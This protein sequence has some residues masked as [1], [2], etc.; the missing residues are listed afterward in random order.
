MPTV[1][2]FQLHSPEHTHRENYM[3]TTFKIFQEK[4]KYP[5][6]RTIVTTTHT[7]PAPL[8]K[9]DYSKIDDEDFDRLIQPVNLQQY[10]NMKRQLATLQAI[11]SDNNKDTLYI[12]LEDD[13]IIMPEFQANLEKFL[14]N[15]FEVDWD[16]MF[17]CAASNGPDPYTPI[18]TIFKILPSKEAYAI[19]PYVIPSL[20]TYFEKTF[21]TFRI[22]LS[23][24][25]LLNPSIKAYCPANRISLEGSKLGFMP[26]TTHENNVLIYNRE[27]M[28]LFKMVTNQTPIDIVQAKRIYKS[29]EHLKSPEMMHLLGVLLF[30][31]QKPFQAKEL[32]LDAITE[33]M[34]QGGL[35]TARS[36]LLN[37]AINIHGITQD[38][39]PAH[40]KMI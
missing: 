14:Q 39:L 27:F 7:D 1:H 18:H 37:N 12:I 20:L 8:S 10:S 15:P 23:R 30:K 33:S 6:K 34:N 32:F 24:W 35:L 38:D 31:S 28:E 29:V 19:K 4:C 17:L 11:L 25:L 3:N 2:L 22:Q 9:I 26:S 36:E 21:Y 40:K 13:A 5:L 16:L